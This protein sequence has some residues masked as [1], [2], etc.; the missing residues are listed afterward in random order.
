MAG[1]FAKNDLPLE[2]EAKERVP[3]PLSSPSLWS[4]GWEEW[5]PREPKG[6]GL[7]P[8]LELSCM[9]VFILNISEI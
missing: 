2:K 1:T 3:L 5:V 7:P 6:G 4:G 9:Q 8:P